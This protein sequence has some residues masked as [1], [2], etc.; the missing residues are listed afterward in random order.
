M[1]WSSSRVEHSLLAKAIYRIHISRHVECCLL[2]LMARDAVTKPSACRCQCTG[3]LLGFGCLNSDFKVRYHYPSLAN[4]VFETLIYIQNVV[5]PGACAILLSGVFK[6]LQR[7]NLEIPFP[8]S[9][10]WM[11]VVAY[12]WRISQTWRCIPSLILP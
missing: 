10:L 3:N 6:V 4:A 7:R 12:T 11:N 1:I 5:R 2:L 9:P 8:T